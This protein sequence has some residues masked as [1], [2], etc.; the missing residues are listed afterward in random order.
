M[1]FDVTVDTRGL[2]NLIRDL[3]RECSAI[4]RGAALQIG[5]WARLSAP[6]DTSFLRNSIMTRVVSPLEA[7]VFVGAFYGRFVEEGTRRA[8]AQPYLGPAVRRGEDLMQMLWTRLLE[9]YRG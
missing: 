7:W 1:G 3:P 4:V 8:R 6:V 9:K 2:D 5:G